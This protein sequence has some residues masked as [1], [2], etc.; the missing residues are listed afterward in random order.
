MRVLLSW[1]LLAIVCYGTSQT[2]IEFW[3][4]MG[5][6]EEAVDLLAEAFNASQSDYR[7]EPRYVGAYPEGQTRLQ[8][9]FGGSAQPSLFQAELSFFP[10]LIDVGAVA[11]LS[12][13]TAG[14]PEAFVNDF[15]PGLWQYGEVDNERYGLP[16]NMSMPV[17]FYNAS[18]FE[19][20]RA[21]APSTWQEFEAAAAR[22][23]TRQTRGF[24]AVA[25]SWTFEM[26]VTTRGGRLVTEDGRPD[27]TNEK[28]IEALQL[29]RQMVESGHAIP[30]NLAETDFAILDFVRTKAMMVF[31]SIANWPDAK[32]FAVAFDIAA[33]PVPT[34]AGSNV[35]L[36]GAQLVV[37]AGASE[38]ERQGAFAFW[39][40][41]MQ[42]ENIR[43]WVEA[44][45]YLPVR[46]S[47]L[48]LLEPWYLEDPNRRAALSQLETAIPRP[49]I[50]DYATWQ[51]YLEEAIEKAI[52]QSVP[53]ETALEEAQR[54][55]ETT[56]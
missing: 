51:R 33:S 56:P 27:F 23:T 47:A 31:A 24:I 12:D 48:P 40:F 19:Q 1:L 49:R 28:S 46:R 4:S 2:T 30:R 37:M 50:P 5:S 22:L 17:L 34:S 44:S 54:R 39:Q 55:A 41:L 29:L 45:F 14:L 13:L 21:A 10:F 25:D 15:F 8:A 7:V 43:T 9:A 16:W 42:P 38:A 35:P 3:H 36:G 52:K 20:R 26:M 18:A 53:A 11:N 32:R 6:T